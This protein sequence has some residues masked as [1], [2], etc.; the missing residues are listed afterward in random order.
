MIFFD[1]K[2]FVSDYIYTFFR[3]DFNLSWL[4]SLIKPTISRYNDSVALRNKNVFDTKHTGQVLSLEHLLNIKID[5]VGKPIKIIDTATIP[6][7]YIGADN[8]IPTTIL[9]SY[10]YNGTN[11]D[12]FP[13]KPY[14]GTDTETPES[15]YILWVGS[16]ETINEDT[17]D[18]SVLVD[19]LDYVDA[20]KLQLI[21]F[22]IDRYK[23]GGYTYKITPY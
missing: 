10:D 22:Y 2:Q 1:F 21:K 5:V 13:N 12:Y 23:L 4:N 20:E 15:E 8:E 16:D 17:L 14:I 11:V 7:W 19:T 9:D 6:Q 18:F 3:N